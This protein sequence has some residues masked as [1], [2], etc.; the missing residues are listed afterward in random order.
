MNQE[1]FDYQGQRHKALDIFASGVA[2]VDPAPM[3]QDHILLSGSLLTVRNGNENLRFDLSK[4]T[5]VLVVG[6]GKATA[7]MALGLEAVLESKITR[8]VISVKY[9]HTEVL[10]TIDTVEAGHPVPDENSVHASRKILELVDTADNDTLV[11]TLIS[12]GG[13][14]LLTLPYFDEKH[15]LDLEDIQ[16]STELLLSSGAPIGDM[17][18]VRKHL[19]G[20]SGGRLAA[21]IAARGATGLT[22]IL[23]DVLGDNLESIAS[24]PTVGDPSTFADVSGILK[25]YNIFNLVPE[26]VQHLVAAGVREEVADTPKPQD[27]IFSK[28]HNILLGTNAHALQAAAKKAQEYGYHVLVLSSQISGEAREVAKVCAG[29]ARDIV[30]RSLPLQEPACVILGGET[31]VTLRGK[32][33]G[34]RNQEMALAFLAEI[35]G[36]PSAFQRVCFLSAGTDGNDGPTDAAGALVNPESSQGS[37]QQSLQQSDQNTADSLHTLHAYLDNNDSY[38]YFQQIGGLIKTGPTNTN[39]CDIQIILVG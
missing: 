29:I 7:K 38:H 39:V 3:I 4:Y 25:R 24:G 2:R 31:T 37:L 11:I 16:K 21:R 28:I 26:S 19:S 27:S 10:K 13:S 5:R 8:G 17:N 32:G 22:L 34:G 6:A 33:K 1:P 35:A 36:Q 18:R 23:S 9:G 12:G 15:K 30:A 14:S 20:I